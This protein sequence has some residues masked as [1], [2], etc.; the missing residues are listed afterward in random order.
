M[1]CWYV[2][3]TPLRTHMCPFLLGVYLEMDQVSHRMYVCY[4]MVDRAGQISMAIV[5]CYHPPMTCVI[6]V[7][8]TFSAALA[9]VGFVAPS[10]W[11]MCDERSYRAMA[12]F[13]CWQVRSGSSLVLLGC[14]AVFPWMLLRPLPIF[15][16]RLSFFACCFQG[17]FLHSAHRSLVNRQYHLPGWLTFHSSFKHNSSF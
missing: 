17:F 9:A 1:F 3:V 8:S 16:I 13:P 14:P 15:R 5:Q 7:F 4:S 12:C 2:L 11:G 10:H 6:Y